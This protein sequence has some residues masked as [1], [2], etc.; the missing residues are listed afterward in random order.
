MSSE[1]TAYRQLVDALKS[2]NRARMAGRP[3]PEV[4]LPPWDADT[5][6]AVYGSLAPN[7]VNHHVIADIPGEW[8][9]GFVRGTVRMKGWGSHVGFPGMTWHPGSDDRV[10]IRLFASPELQR[11]WSRID[12][13]EGEDYV[14][15]LVPV[16]G[17][18][19]MPLVANI[20]QLRED[21]EGD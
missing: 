21:P 3:D 7:Q 11:H 2:I 13:F 20:Y 17:M 16:E 14:R 9:D 12:D 19:E 5:R 15:I 10:P 4:A 18:G 8:T 1:E 6:L